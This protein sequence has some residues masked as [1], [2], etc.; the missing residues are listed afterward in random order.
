MNGVDA[1]LDLLHQAIALL[2]SGRFNEALQLLARIPGDAALHP[3]ALH[4]RGIAHAGQ[5]ETIQ[6][7]ASFEAA[8]PHLADNQE[9]LANLARAYAAHDRVADALALLDKIAETGKASAI[10]FVDRAILL[11]RLGEY[12]RALESCD[13]A[14]ALDAGLHLAWA[15]KG[16]LLHTAE[17]Y[18]EA[19]SCHDRVIAFQPQDA[20]A[21]SARA[22]TLDKMGR[23]VEALAGHRHAQVLCPGN[24]AI[25]SGQGVC[26]VLLDRLEEGL[27]C[28]DQALAIDPSHVQAKINRASVLAELCRF[29]ES[30]EQFDA[31]LR[32][33]P[34]GSKAYAQAVTNR[35]RV[36]LALGNPAG[37]ADCEHR[38]FA[39]KAFDH[40]SAAAPRWTGAED[41]SGKRIVLW[42]EQ[43]YGDII[44]FCRYTV[45]LA[46]LGAT[47]LLQ[48]PTRLM[49]LCASLPAAT[50]LE[51]GAA[52]PPYDFHIPMM[53]MPLA[54]QGYPA[55]AAIPCPH[56]YLRAEPYHVE[57]WKDVL[58]RRTGKLR[59]GI[60]C[61]GALRHSR[62]AR[63][64]IPLEKMLPLTNVAD[65]FVLQPELA[66][67]DLAVA[68][69]HSDILRPPLDSGDFA[70][71]AGL[72]ANLDLVISVDTSIA[73]LAGAMGMPVWI[74]L[75]W[76][77]E[78]RWMTARA[79]TPW[80]RSARLFRQPARG[81]WDF[82]I[83]DVLAA[84]AT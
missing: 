61:S 23:M 33:A 69:K 63:R 41:L 9:L 62:N 68:E 8:L 42:G 64:S 81:R 5:R 65:L 48:V 51:Q 27:A 19:L 30:L 7:V 59:I 58:P 38:S 84:L 18:A 47:V 16:N 77:A 14:L 10:T 75:P 2:S 29:P 17:R 55:L 28:F 39:E 73:H 52:T 82:V 40:H 53:S 12:S 70:D 50:V 66:P 71:V 83:R 1:H 31:A 80:Y 3:H 57:R 37:W 11:E 72:I 15:T 54:L 56:G 25:W 78:W 49:P 21:R 6:A 43:G 24:A 32:F 34:V 74:L 76:N 46:E 20:F 4:L 67:D 60:A 79:D 45:S 13:A 26:L 22:S 36:R 44:Q 35:G